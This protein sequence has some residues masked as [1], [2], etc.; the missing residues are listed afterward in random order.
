[1]KL[2]KNK[3]LL[4][5]LFFVAMWLFW[6][7][8][9]PALLAYQ[10]ETQLFLFDVE[11]FISLVAMPTGIARY[12][13]E[14]V[15]QTYNFLPLGSALLAAITIAMQLI[16][17]Q[18]AKRASREQIV[19]FVLTF[20]PVVLLW[21]FQG[22][23]RVKLAFTIALL[24]TEVAM[25]IAQIVLQ[26]S[27]KTLYY[28]LLLIITPLLAWIAGPAVLVFALFVVLQRRHIINFAMVLYA[29]LC[30]MLTSVWAAAPLSRFFQGIGY[31]M[32]YDQAMPMQYIVMLT[33]AVVP[34]VVSLVPQIKKAKLAQYVS[35]AAL[36]AATILVSANCIDAKTY[37][38][39]E[40]NL[41]V[42]AGKWDDII[43]QAEKKT[44]DTPL[45]VASLNLALAMRG[46]LLQ[47]G[48][49]F[50][51][52][53][54]EG[55][56]PSFNK[57]YETS[58]LTAEIYYFL[59]LINTAQRLDFEANEALADNCKS[60]RVVKRLAETNLI[61]GQ[62]EVARKYLRLLQKTMFYQK[63]ATRTLAL[64]GDEKAIDSHPIYGQLRR[65][66]LA[67]D[68][69]FSDSEID[70]IMGRLMV[71][72]T[73]NSLAVQY[74]LFLPQLEGNQQK[75]KLYLDLVNKTIKQKP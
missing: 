37:E 74:F 40:Y 36:C 54:W 19:G 33:V 72:N 22:E 25:W 15:V 68:F 66:R 43:A 17:W 55:A 53:G 44:P 5:L 13:A 2:L 50:Y 41:L 61:N 14:F 3:Y 58:V 18:I 16:M 64:V 8:K 63:W 39:L 38:T 75:Y 7:L 24:M 6:L 35:V 29:P 42:R 4:S 11:H 70:K 12:V 46:Q 9:A 10:E 1:M 28:V 52:N 45:T 60:V 49:N 21:F 51:Q 69:M 71:H 31:T 30:I 57:Y 27:C 59:G 26:R 56:F 73:D 23:L 47:R 62:Y 34:F 67:E 65:L 20:V 32:L 48:F